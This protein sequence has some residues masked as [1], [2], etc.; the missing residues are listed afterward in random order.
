MH[1]IDIIIFAQPFNWTFVVFHL[2][3]GHVERERLTNYP[4]AY[5]T[6]NGDKHFMK[7]NHPKEFSC[8]IAC[9]MMKS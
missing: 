4:Q 7:E 5:V 3:L 6:L 2:S 8:I 9:L 1:A